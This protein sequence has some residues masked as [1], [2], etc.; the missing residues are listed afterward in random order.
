M[1]ITG[2]DASRHKGAVGWGSVRRAGH[3]FAILKATDDTSYQY[4]DWFHREFPKAKAAGLIAGAYHFLSNDHDGASQARYYVREVNRRGGFRG[5]LA[6]VDVEVDAD[7]SWP[8]IG[9]VRQ[10][11]SEFRR[12]VPRHALLIYTGRWF[13]QASRYL[14]NPVGANL[15]AL[16]HSEYETT[17]AEVADGPEAYRYGG[18]STW[19]VWQYTATGRCPGVAGDCD[20]NRFNGTLAALR[21]LAGVSTPT[22]PMENDMPWILVST[23]LQ[24]Y[25][26]FGD[27]AVAI[28]SA[29]EWETYRDIPGVPVRRVPKATYNLVLSRINVK[30]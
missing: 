14:N 15:G 20:L 24:S 5:V 25:I 6:A 12:L 13:W 7:G 21:A 27:T 23:G 19:T 28:R 16:W 2:I 1:A 29:A 11:V 22:Q 3:T 17:A 30:H 9:Q 18:W 8:S 10:F 4:I 26:V